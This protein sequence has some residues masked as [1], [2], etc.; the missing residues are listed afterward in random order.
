MNPTKQAIMDQINGVAAGLEDGGPLG[1]L[2]PMLQVAA[3]FGMVDKLGAFLPDDELELCELLRETARFL[4]GLCL[5]PPPGELEAA[6]E[7]EANGAAAAATV[8]ESS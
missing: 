1:E 5:L 6:G 4:E 8:R 7:L 3:A 2:A